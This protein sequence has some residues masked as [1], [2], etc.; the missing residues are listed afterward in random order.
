MTPEDLLNELSLLSEDE[1][2]D[3]L[4]SW[5]PLHDQSFRDALA[6]MLR[7][8]ERPVNLEF[9]RAW[10]GKYAD[11]TGFLRA[12][13]A[14]AQRAV[15]TNGYKSPDNRK[16]IQWMEATLDKEPNVKP[17]EL[18]ERCARVFGHAEYAG[19]YVDLAQTVKHCRGARVRQRD[20][21]ERAKTGAP[22]PVRAPRPKRPA[23]TV[24]EQY[25]PS[26]RTL[27][28]LYA[29]MA[30]YE[31]YL[32]Q[33]LGMW[34]RLLLAGRFLAEHGDCSSVVSHR[35]KDR[36]AHDWR[37]V[38]DYRSVL[39]RVS[40]FDHSFFVSKA[41]L[42]LCMTKHSGSALWVGPAPPWVSRTTWV[43]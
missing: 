24:E 19:E 37:R 38:P 16:R 13:L 6:D 20:L 35:I 1:Q 4:R 42:E 23:Y 43:R 36:E 32:K 2:I 40:L 34:D 28:D 21:R 9:F 39:E 5:A 22:A 15:A 8:L 29:V 31:N 11:D 3:F 7:D 14:E 10:V 18:A 33:H 41:A 12:V 30:P 17:A 26:R 27:D 25:V